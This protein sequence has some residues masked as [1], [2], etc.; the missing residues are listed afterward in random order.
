MVGGKSKNNK[1]TDSL[2]QAMKRFD[3]SWNYAKLNWH[4]KW[5]RDIHLYDNERV[6]ATYEGTTDTFVPMVFSTIE[7][8][9]AALSNAS[10]RFEFKS[11]NPMTKTDNK[12]L[13]ALIGEWW[14]E[15]QWDLAIEE[16]YR[17]TLNV[18]MV[19]NMF[20]WDYE[21]DRPHLESFAMR[22][23]VVDPTIKK[24]ADLQK[25]GSYAGRRYFVRKGSLDNIKVVD[26][27]PESKTYGELIPRYKIDSSEGGSNG[28]PDDKATKEMFDDSTLVTAEKDQDEIIEIWDVDRVVTI[29]N[30]RQVIEDE[31]NP[32]KY[33]HEL[34]LLDKYTEAGYEDAATRAKAE[35]KGIVPFFFGR[36]YR[37]LSLFYATS[38]VNSIAKEQELLNDLTNM[39]TDYIIKQ[40][41][42]Q[43]ELDPKYAD[44]IDMVTSDPDVVYPFVPGSLVDRAV[45][46]LPSNSFNNR[47]NIKNEIRET[48]AIDQV[49]K[50]VQNVKDTTATEVRAQLNQSGQ[51]IQSKARI[52][53]KDYFYWMGWILVKFVQLYIDKPM[54]VEIPGGSNINNQDA[55][56]KY[57]IELPQGT[58]VFDPADLPDDFQVRVS[59]DIDQRN[60]EADQQQQ[61]LTAYTT[62]INDPSNAAGG[63]NLPELKKRLYPKIFNLDQE[64]IDAILTP[65]EP[66]MAPM[67][68]DPMAGG[69]PPEM[70]APVDPALGA[71][72][73]F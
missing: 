38:E 53:E 27:D 18:G 34:K 55:M 3:D 23:A 58:G 46:V 70:G 17:E 67:G 66:A 40:L 73:G 65:E 5:D 10:P 68:A 42:P 47:M 19:A 8:M 50:G 15:D 45:P 9:V 56:E 54:V 22:D 62:I 31:V 24:P 41:A 39:E 35:A 20:S 43:K 33:K 48:T 64:D 72:S 13:N 4:S 30:R 28:E 25:P 61:M 12:A 52:F 60:K 6:H 32:F 1:S 14:D 26:T 37:K 51:R 69:L 44:W 57:G 36:N 21:N 59:L 49:A 29:M 7:T 71:P 2:A 63:I 16:G 11:G